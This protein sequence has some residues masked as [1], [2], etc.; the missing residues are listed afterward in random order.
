MVKTMVKQ[1]V[2]LQ[3]MEVHWGVEIHLQPVEEPCMQVDAKGSCDL[4]VFREPKEVDLSASET[5]GP[6]AAAAILL[7]GAPKAVF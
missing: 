2:P 1:P 7:A 3:P 6:Q 5:A 4:V